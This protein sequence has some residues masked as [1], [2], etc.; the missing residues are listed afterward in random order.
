MR[1]AITRAVSPRINQCELTFRDREPIDPSVAAAQHDSY[2]K[3][4][5]AQGVKVIHAEAAPQNPDGVFVEDAAIVLDEIAIITRPGAPS[6]RGETDSVGRALL[7]YRAVRHMTEPAT[8]D[9]GDLLRMGHTLY[10]GRSQRTNDRAFS[11]LRELVG[12]LGYTVVPTLLLDCLHLKTA[13]TAVGDRTILFNPEC[14][15]GR[16]FGDVETIAVHP[17]EPF[18]ANVLRIGDRL[19]MTDASPKT[20]AILEERGFAVD[21]IDFDSGFC[22]RDIGWREIKRLK[23]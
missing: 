7:R 22:R 16:V 1:I 21:S 15:E 23:G 3:W 12:P 13:A 4:L 14:V 9:G 19:L 5:E 11:Q 18:A 6:R 2:E 8:I 10:L 20:R 17:S